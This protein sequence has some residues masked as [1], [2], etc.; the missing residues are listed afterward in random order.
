MKTKIIMPIAIALVA[1]LVILIGCSKPGGPTGATTS[2]TSQTSNNVYVQSLSTQS[3][4][5]Q[6]LSQLSKA[7]VVDSTSSGI[8]SIGWNEFVGPNIIESGT[9]GEAFA[10]V[11]SDTSQ[12]EIRPSGI[13]IGTVSVTYGGSSSVVLT[14]QITPDGG[15]LYS[16][17]NRGL[18]DSQ[19]VQINIPFISNGTYQ[20]DVS[21]SASFSAGSFIINAPA[22]LLSITSNKDEDTISTSNDLTLTWS[23]GSQ[24]DSVLIRIVPHLHREQIEGRSPHDE[25]SDTV[26]HGEGPDND[27]PHGRLSKVT[28]DRD[29][30]EN[31]MPFNL[32]SEF[33]KGIILT[34]ANTGTV[35][36]SAS[37]LQNLLSGTESTELMVGVTQVIKNNIQHDNKMLKLILR[38]G[39]RI[40]LKIK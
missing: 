24:S 13:D 32:G 14:K 15:V 12:S 26:H 10:V 1:S 33:K 2:N 21:G 25:P 34:V 17:F 8:F 35:T 23:G 38:N 31:K 9:K 28:C 22:S 18:E 36:I 39:T 7:S 6:D 40:I 27:G 30:I 37:D 11:H 4:V 19:S 29:S 3:V 16:T 20:F 5:V